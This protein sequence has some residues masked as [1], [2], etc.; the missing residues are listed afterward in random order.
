MDLLK[1]IEDFLKSS[2]MS[3]TAFG[4]AALNDPPFVQQ[5]RKGRDIKMSTAE[6]IRAFIRDAAGAPAQAD[7][8]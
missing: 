1:E 3:A 4:T 7:A 6:R 8:A 2:G 5:L